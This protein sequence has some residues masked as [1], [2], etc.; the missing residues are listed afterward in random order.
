MAK[1]LPDLPFLVRDLGGVRKGEFIHKPLTIFCGP[2]NSG[3]TWVLYS[4]YYFYSL[5]K[6]HTYGRTRERHPSLAAF[7]RHLSNTL[8]DLFNTSSEKFNGAAFGMTNARSWSRIMR[9]K[10]APDAFLMPAERSGLHLFFRELSTRRTALLHHASKENINIAALLRDVIRS[11]YA[12]PIAQYIDWLNDLTSMRKSRH[13][14][15]HKH[16][17]QLKKQLAGGA[18]RVDHATGDIVF[19][20]Y[21]IARKVKTQPMGLHMTSSTVK[22]LFG[23][24]FYLEY[25]ARPGDI[26]MIDEPELNIHPDNQRKVS[27]IL[28][29]LV[30]AGLKI[31]I[32]THS[33]YIVRE[34]NSLIMLSQD[35]GR[36]LQNMY[37]YSEDEILTAGQVGAYLFDDRT[38]TAFDISPHDGILATTF[39]EV[40]EDLNEVNNGIYYALQEHN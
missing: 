35:R 8:S 22:S 9:N 12:M 21:Q 14:A 26:L 33:D 16:A 23:L 1:Y 28:A 6:D 15:F 36:V 10:Y 25:Q 29:K 31:V 2:N 39:D 3:K 30:N 4:L 40:I 13:K 24:W 37:G 5:L 38:I 27:R 17:E 18:Y 34:F 19:K 11:R 32:S 20:P 7:N